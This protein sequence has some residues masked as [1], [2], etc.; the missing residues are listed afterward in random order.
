MHCLGKTL[1]AFALLNFVLQGQICLLLQ[2]SLDFLL[3]HSAAAAAKWLQS[4]L[5]LCDPMDSTPPGSSVHGFSR[6]EYW[7]GLPFP[8]PGKQQWPNQNFFLIV[9]EVRCPKW[10]KIKVWAGQLLLESPSSICFLPSPASRGTHIPQL[11]APPLSSP[12]AAQHL[13][14]GR[15]STLICSL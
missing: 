14:P 6:Q 2:V 9:L 10:A 12:S 7:S 8:P 5:T 1:L 13:L 15:C 4:C 3:L 11:V